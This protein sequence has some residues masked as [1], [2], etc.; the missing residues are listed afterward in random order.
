MVPL[1]L[2]RRSRT[3]LLQSA[4]RL[5]EGGP[6]LYRRFIPTNNQDGEAEA[7]QETIRTARPR[8]KI[9]ASCGG[10]PCR[11]V[12]DYAAA[13]AAATAARRRRAGLLRLRFRRRHCCSALLRCRFRC[14]RRPRPPPLHGR[15]GPGCS[16]RVPRAQVS[17][18][19]HLPAASDK[20]AATAAR[21]RRGSMLLRCRRLMPLL[22]SSGGGGGGGGG[23][24]GSG[25]WPAGR[26][27]S[28]PLP[29]LPPPATAA[30]AAA[31]L[32]PSSPYLHTPVPL[33]LHPL[34]TRRL[35]NPFLPSHLFPAH[36]PNRR[37][38]IQPP[39]A[40][41]AGLRGMAGSAAPSLHPPPPATQ[42]G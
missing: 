25:G 9:V 16:V 14:C 36:S 37:P 5:P 42:L 11:S 1:S 41:A 31:G 27:S 33:S 20:A 17:C 21:P 10:G 29:L 32:L 24:D 2:Q 28:S 35:P 34:P 6:D 40:A 4:I 30:A 19:Q 26:A 23:G 18:R 22:L 3:D 38:S 8:Q 12:A 13:A 39:A 15:G 7:N